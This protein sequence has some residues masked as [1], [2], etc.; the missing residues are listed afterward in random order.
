AGVTLTS[1]PELAMW[2]LDRE[3]RRMPDEAIDAYQR[4]VQVGL[5]PSLDVRVV[6]WMTGLLVAQGRRDE[7][8]EA[9]VALTTRHPGRADAW[10]ARGEIDE[11]P[12][13]FDEAHA[14]SPT[15]AAVAWGRH[16]LTHGR[17]AEALEVCA[18]QVER[19]PDD[20]DAWALLG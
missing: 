11:D 1:G 6:R 3:K 16:L 2:G 4:A 9:V 13:S 19:D 7:A 5:D 12:A 15:D 20:C 10:L 14:L 8:L 18:A 17:K